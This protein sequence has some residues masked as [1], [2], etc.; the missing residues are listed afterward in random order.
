[1]ELL[2]KKEKDLYQKLRAGLRRWLKGKNK[3]AN[4]V[5]EIVLAAP[6]LFH[7]IARLAADK[8]VPPAKKKTLMLA[9]AYYIAPIDILPEAAIGPIGYIE[10]VLLGAVVLNDFIN[11]MDPAL[12]KKYWAGD[13]NVLAFL[14]TVV[15]RAKTI[16]GPFVWKRLQKV[17]GAGSAVVS[18][19]LETGKRK[20]A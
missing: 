16:V 17:I 3:T 5:V 8:R 10:D 18:Q 7:L 2:I 19:V 1:M 15:D 14:E 13:W 9:L 4:R 20:P 6:D 11:T 12:I